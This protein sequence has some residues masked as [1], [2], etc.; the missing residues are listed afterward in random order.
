MSS[1]EVDDLCKTL[2][3]LQLV[4]QSQL[5]ECLHLP[6]R[7]N[8]NA[9]EFLESL[10]LKGYLTSFQ[11]SR[12][13]KGE[14]DGLVLGGCKLM[15]QNAS[16]SF[17]R[18]YRGCNL[19]NG[20]MLGLKVLRQRWAKDPKAV[21][22]F[23]REAELGKS[24]KHE[25]IVPIFDVGQ[26]GDHHYL[27]M[28]FIEGG[29]L[30]DFINIRKKLS[31]AEATKCALEMTAGLHYA[32]GRGFTHRDLKLTNVLMS[33]QGVAMLV[34]FG[35]AGKSVDGDR[36]K[37]E[38]S[39]QRALE[40]ATLEKNTGAPRDDPRSDLYFLGAIYYELLTGV[41]PLPRTRDRAERSEFSRYQDVQPIRLVAPDLPRPVERTVDKLMQINPSL[42][43][44][45]AAEA[46]YDLRAGASELGGGTGGGA[47][48]GVQVRRPAATLDK[49]AAKARRTI[50][51]IE[52]RPKQQDMLRDYFTR[53]HFRVLVLGDLQ[54]GVARVKSSPP[55]YVLVMAE[56]AGDAAVSGFRDLQKTMAGTLIAGV[57]V[58]PEKLA[59]LKQKLKDTP[60][61]RVMP[62][63]VTLRELRKSL[64]SIRKSLKEAAGEEDGS[65]ME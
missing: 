44:Q 22:E 38:E 32:I 24:L 62:Q 56:S 64:R 20:K 36:Q 37:R 29:N 28:E 21:Q 35:L 4:S 2:L 65:E 18:V 3:R 45:S 26:S 11:A 48:T 31:P 30:R 53:H 51:C 40:Y 43:Y 16:G 52:S 27:T 10:E 7:A 13:K 14:V 46:L 41:P 55:E 47:G 19:R 17:A 58:L 15:Y 6:G 39:T 50:M 1:A 33:S 59:E 57:L 34:D 12:L 63:P 25:N 49:P 42:R 9:S 5:E 61:A 23:H 60:N 54:R 8:G